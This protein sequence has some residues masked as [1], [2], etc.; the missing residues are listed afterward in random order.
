MDAIMTK[1]TTARVGGLSVH[2][3]H[4]AVQNLRCWVL[5]H[6]I[7]GKEIEIK[8]PATVKARTKRKNAA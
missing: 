3:D 2:L 8:S 6:H 1:H 7:F 4:E 5:L